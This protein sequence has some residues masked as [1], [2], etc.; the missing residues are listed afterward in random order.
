MGLKMNL[1]RR[2]KPGVSPTIWLSAKKSGTAGK[3]EASVELVQRA[4]E[5][6]GTESTSPALI[7]LG[8]ISSLSKILGV[9][10]DVI[11]DKMDDLA[12][13]SNFFHSRFLCL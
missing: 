5:G 11:V 4:L 10:V 9:L 2:R 3:A 12:K 6:N 13:V 1:P 7:L 8:N